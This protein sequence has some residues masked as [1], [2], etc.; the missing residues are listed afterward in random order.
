[1]AYIWQGGSPAMF[2]QVAQGFVNFGSGG[3]GR[4]REA[5]GG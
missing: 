1:M 4:R 5:S 2:L 3:V